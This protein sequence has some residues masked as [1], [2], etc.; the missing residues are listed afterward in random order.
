MRDEVNRKVMLDLFA[1]PFTLVPV[2]GGLT[3]LILSVGLGSM[4]MAGAGI[5][6]TL[7]GLGIFSTKLIFGLDKITEKAYKSIME[8]REKARNDNLDHLDRV[9]RQD[10]DPRPEQ[11]LVQL[12]SMHKMLKEAEDNS[13]AS[14]ILGEFERLFD[15]CVKQIVKTDEL[16]RAY[17]QMNGAVKQKLKE[18]REQIVSE[19]E[20][21]TQQLALSVQQ[22]K[23]VGSA[24][25]DAELEEAKK[26]F[27]Q[28]IVIAKR[29]DERL[30]NLNQKSYDIKEFE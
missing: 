21:T 2:I 25:N 19:I 9:L 5:M 30:A 26:E 10:K 8:E 13:L 3:L 27:E 24:Q 7:V 23:T 16:W 29:V 28:R 17:R 22:I 1:S 12:R 20:A 6:S 4:T 15:I 18:Q 14:Q 11:C